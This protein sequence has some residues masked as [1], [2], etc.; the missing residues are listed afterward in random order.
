MSEHPNQGGDARRQSPSVARNREPILAQLRERLAPQARVLEIASGTGEHAVYFTANWP[1]LTWQPSDPDPDA[2]ASIAAWRA[3]GPGDR[4]APPAALEV[5]TTPW[6]VS[7]PFDA[8]VCCNMIHIAPWQACIDLLAGAAGHLDPGGWLM[9]YGP[10]FVT[11]QTS[12]ASNLR[13]DADLR[14]RHPDWGIRALD[15]VAAQA[16]IHGFAAPEAVAMPA[17]NLCVWF[18]RLR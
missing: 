5:G 14:G 13:F 11:G 16:R 6:P 18:E 7:G 4:I 2:R 8:V 15:D 3:H 10:F 12:A 9:L 1:G 17:N